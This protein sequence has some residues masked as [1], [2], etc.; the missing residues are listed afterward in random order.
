MVGAGGSLSPGGS[1]MSAWTFVDAV[2]VA[3][4]LY[5]VIGWIWRE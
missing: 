4:V 5:V 3:G 2:V 1:A